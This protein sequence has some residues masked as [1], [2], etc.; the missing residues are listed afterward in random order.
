MGEALQASMFWRGNLS[1]AVKRRD[2]KGTAWGFVFLGILLFL[3]VWQHMHVVKLGYE[4]ETLRKQRQD[5]MNEH[6]YLK[7][8]LNEVKSLSRVERVAREEL[9]MITPRTGQVVILDDTETLTSRWG[10]SWSLMLK[11]WNTR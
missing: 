10:D 2:F 3:Y 4:V 5:L 6:Y 11:K 7:Y 8:R 9:G 1:R